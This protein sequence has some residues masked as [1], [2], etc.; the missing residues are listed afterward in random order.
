MENN[1][2][3]S[4]LLIETGAYKDLDKPVILTSGELGIYYINT[5]KLCQDGGKFNDYG[6]DSAA[7]INHA[8]KMTKEHPIFKETIDILSEETKKLGLDHYCISGGQRRDWLFSGPVARNLKLYHVSLYKGGD[9]ELLDSNANLCSQEP[10]DL[11]GL[12]AVHIADLITEGS[13]IYRIENSEEKGWVPMLRENEA[14]I[15]NLLAVVTRLQGG[16]QRLKAVG[17]NTHSFV[18]IDEDFLGKYSKNPE[19]AL[20]YQKNPGEF[21]ENYLKENGAMAFLS[22]F[23]PNGG[24]ID[25]AKKFLSRYGAI[26][27]ESGKI[28][29]L[30]SAVKEKYGKSLDGIIGDK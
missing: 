28:L 9:I 3:I 24:K 26:L 25:R 15:S 8:V 23:D 10:L 1:K 20:A 4:E 5:E 2:R 29:E 16:E 6:N 11:E 21:S 12:C 19:R 14:G 13:S 17:V 22:S 30:E 7:M 27:K 18:A